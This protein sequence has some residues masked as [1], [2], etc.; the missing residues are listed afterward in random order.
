L[1]NLIGNHINSPTYLF[2]I[3]IFLMY[4]D[5]NHKLTQ[6]K[7]RLRLFPSRKSLNKILQSCLPC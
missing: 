5:D 2:L 7:I 4:S 1:A 6:L 3:I